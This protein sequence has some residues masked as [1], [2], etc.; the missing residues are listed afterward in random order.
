MRVRWLCARARAIPVPLW[1]LFAVAAVVAGVLAGA[2]VAAQAS[3]A[4]AVVRALDDVAGDR[5]DVI[6][7]FEPENSERAD[8][9]SAVSHALSEMDAAGALSDVDSDSLDRL[10]YRI[11]AAGISTSSALALMS[12]LSDLG[13]GIEDALGAE[14]Q[15][16]GGLRTSLLALEDGIRARQAIHAVAWA[17]LFLAAVVVM[18]TVAVEPVR[19]RAGENRLLRA[20]GARRRWLAA[21][22]A[23]E[24]AVIAGAGA[25]GGAA[26]GAWAAAAI[27]GLRVPWM[28]AAIAAVGVLIVAVLAAVIATV[29]AVDVR[30]GRADVAAAGGAI[31]L[32]VVLASVSVWQFVATSRRVSEG[33]T[34]TVD[35]IVVVAPG[36]VLVLAAL[37]AVIVATPLAGAAAR[38]SARGRTVSPTLGLRLLARRPG[39]HALTMSVVAIAIGSF[40]FAGCYGGTIAALGNAP[41]ALRVGADVR[42]VSVPEDMML[43]DLDLSDGVDASMPVR[44]FDARGAQE[45]VPV[46]AAETSSLSEVMLDADGAMDTAGVADDLAP[47]I[48]GIP[49]S[50]S[51]DALEVRIRTGER[52]ELDLDGMPVSLGPAPIVASIW[53]VS[54][55]GALAVEEAT[56]FDIEET[57]FEGGTLTTT[58]AES[59]RSTTIDLPSGEWSLAAVSVGSVEFFGSGSTARVDVSVAGQPLDLSVLSPTAGAEIEPVQTGLSVRIAGSANGEAVRDAYA[60]A[61]GWPSRPAATLTAELAASMAVEPGDVLSLRA[62]AL[63][64]TVDF[65]V[66]SLVDVLPGAPGGSGILTDLS[67]LSMAVG[68]VIAPNEI[69]LSTDDPLAVADAVEAAAPATA[70]VTADPRAAQSA[71]ST[72]SAFALSAVGVGILAVIVLVMRRSSNRT[73]AR[74]LALLDVLGLGR[75]GARRARALEDGVAVVVGAVG[76]VIAGCGSAWFAAPVLARAAY[77]SIPPD[78]VVSLRVDVSLLLLGVASCVAVFTAIATT[79]RGPRVLARWLREDE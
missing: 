9:A 3:E 66:V 58:R 23:I 60:V 52:T 59:D 55:G 17:T 12:G 18:A 76:G 44:T 11:D 38:V 35:P 27:A 28:T 75:R 62:S 30:T 25:L 77:P 16:S 26:A 14:V 31:G 24:T 56:N 57:D 39:R 73:D 41:E 8:V 33:A 13:D 2:G 54:D 72:V 20:R 7:R 64:T 50:A 78:F 53:F 1:G 43:S 67:A 79:V 5:A 37:V 69:W 71:A 40:V 48:D 51:A 70:S 65:N 47:Q 45:N 74:E 34:F 32:L 6:V 68:S 15:V 29:R 63:G 19:V 21:I 46:L 36:L 22:T 61:P 42:V 49:V 10:V 4:S